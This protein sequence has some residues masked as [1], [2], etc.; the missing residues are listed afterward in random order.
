V[1]AVLMSKARHRTPAKAQVGKPGKNRPASSHS[2]ARPRLGHSTL[3]I[4]LAKQKP[5][6]NCCHR[7]SYRSRRSQPVASV[8][9]IQSGA[10]LNGPT[11]PTSPLP[12]NPSQQDI[13]T[14]R[15]TGEGRQAKAE[16][17][18]ACSARPHPRPNQKTK[19]PTRMWC[20]RA[21]PRSE[22]LPRV[23]LNVPKFALLVRLNAPFGSAN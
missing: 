23:P 4:V 6:S 10:T 14:W 19:R 15:L 2:S 16:R 18:R 21:L 11:H 17:A 20:I 7:A 12:P 13:Y 9:R 8:L 3:V 1:S 5:S 22:K